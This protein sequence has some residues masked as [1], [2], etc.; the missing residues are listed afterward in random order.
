LQ[1]LDHMILV[2]KKYA[3]D[4]GN[5][6]SFDTDD[7]RVTAP[8]SNIYLIDIDE[9]TAESLAHHILFRLV[10]MMNDED[11]RGI[12]TL[13][14]DVFESEGRIGGCKFFLKNRT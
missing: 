1:S 10:G 3:I 7:G 12:K 8:R 9:T 11:M 14:I 5:S 4:N 13:R 6:I 2:S